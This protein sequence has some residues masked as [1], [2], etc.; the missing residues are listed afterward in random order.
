MITILKSFVFLERGNEENLR[1][2]FAKTCFETLL[3]FSLLDGLNVKGAIATPETIIPNEELTGHLAVTAL[4]FRFQD[5]IKQY[6]ED[7]RR[8]GNCPLAR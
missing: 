5:V 2:E 3:E 7:E 8:A 6:V 4:L 1:E